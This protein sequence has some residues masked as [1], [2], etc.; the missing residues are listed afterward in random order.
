M[1]AGEKSKWQMLIISIPVAVI[2]ISS[3]IIWVRYIPGQPVEITV[4][5]SQQPIGMVSIEGAVSNP[6]FYP[7][8]PDDNIQDIIQA[9]GGTTSEAD[10]KQINL[11]VPTQGE[12]QPQKININSAD[13]WLLQAL[14]E[15]GEVK[16]Q[17]IIDYRQQ[18]GQFK[19]TA[20]LIKVDGIGLNL[21]DQI[22]HLITVCD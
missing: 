11:Y 1:A 15:I 4:S 10:N 16:A 5:S 18:N 2:V 20:E 8:M 9:A 22:K 6:G 17:A 14:P 13:G 21:Y 19:N 3:I 12:D 7:L